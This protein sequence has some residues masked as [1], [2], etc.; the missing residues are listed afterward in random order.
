MLPAISLPNFDGNTCSWL[1]FRDTF[2]ALIVNNSSL[3][4]VQKCHYLISSLK[5]EAKELISNLQITNENFIVSWQSVTQR[6]N[7]KPLIAMIHAKHLC[8][9]PQVKKGDAATLRQLINHVSSNINALQALSLNVSIQDLVLSHLI[10]ETLDADTLKEWET[11]PARSDVPLITELINF[12]ERR[13]KAFEL[14]QTIHAPRTPVA[15]PRPAQPN[16]GKGDRVI[17]CNVVTQVQCPLCNHSHKLF[18][19]DRFLKMQPRQRLNH[20]KRL[21]LC[22]NCL[23]PFVKNHMRSKQMCRKCNKRHHTLLHIDKQYHGANNPPTDTR[24]STTANDNTYWSLKNKPRNHILLAT[25]IVEVKNNSGKYVPCR[26]LLDS[27]S[28]SHFITE[29]CAQDLRL[30]R[31]PQHVS[32]Q[33]IRNVNTETQ[34]SVSIHLRSRHTDWQTTLDSAILPNITGATPPIRLDATSWHIPKDIKLAD[35]SFSEPGS[36]DI[37]I[38]ADVFYEILRSG[39]QSRPG[40]YPVLQETALGWTISGRTPGV[41]TCDTQHTFMLKKD[42]SLKDNSNCLSEGEQV[43]QSTITSQQQA[44]EGHALIHTTKQSDGRPLVKLPSNMELNQLGTSCLSVEQESHAFECKL[45][46]HPEVKIQ[47]HK[48]MKKHHEL[49]NSGAVKSPVWKKTT[50]CQPHPAVKKK[51]FYIMNPDYS[52]QGCQVYQWHSTPQN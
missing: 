2:E 40:N 34:H 31:T 48:F 17:Q 46:Q 18:K 43:E 30:T 24:A 10:L 5:H 35:D 11:H 21:G 9:M 22:F 12:L 16:E 29:K 33:G 27:A 36:I 14:I 20:V 19:C 51:G 4:D 3:S 23:Q 13:C 1:N 37:L 32:V 28:Q 6:Y 15:S 8:N 50:Y 26:V 44:C 49:D 7:N 45:E 25:A 47:H 42:N 39:S 52:W 38:G 41:T